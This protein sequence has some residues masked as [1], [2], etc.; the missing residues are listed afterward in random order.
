MHCLV[1]LPVFAFSCQGTFSLSTI[2][3]FKNE[4]AK[5]A[6]YGGGPK[7]ARRLKQW[8]PW[9]HGIVGGAHEQPQTAGNRRSSYSFQAG[10]GADYP[11]DSRVS[12]RIEADYVLTG[13]FRQKQNNVQFDGGIVFHF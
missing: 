5:L 7:I 2:S 1:S 4:H 6:V 9:L 3:G 11:W 8:E 10:G 12:F 13:F